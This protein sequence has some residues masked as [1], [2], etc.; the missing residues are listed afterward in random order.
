MKKHYTGPAGSAVNLGI[1]ILGKEENI[2]TMEERI[3]NHV[4]CFC[5]GELEHMEGQAP[6]T[7]GN[8]PDNACTT[9]GARCCDSCNSTI[10]IP[11]RLYTFNAIESALFM[12]HNEEQMGEIK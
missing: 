10:V 9:E 3:K 7:W 4:C 11:V 5:E 2:M 12:K 1:K 6:E 8:N